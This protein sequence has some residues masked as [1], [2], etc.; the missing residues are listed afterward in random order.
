VT[1]NA[2]G[3]LFRSPEGRVLLLRR[4]DTGGWAYPG[5]HIEAGETPAE[6]AVREAME[7]V[8]YK[9]KHAGV[10]HTKRVRNGVNFTT[11]LYDCEEEFVPKLNHEHTDYMWIAPNLAIQKSMLPEKSAKKDDTRADAAWEEGKHPRGPDGKFAPIGS[12]GANP[13][14]VTGW[15]SISG[16]QGY[17]TGG[18]F[19]SPDG[20]QHYVKFPSE[21]A[22]KTEV[23]SG[24]ILKQIGVNTVNPVFQYTNNE[25][26]VSSE[27]DPNL[28]QLKLSDLT[29]PQ[30]L[31][32]EQRVQLAEMYAAAVLTNNWDAIGGEGGMPINVMM[33]EGTKDLTQL[34]L[35]GSFDFK[36]VGSAKPF[37][38]DPTDTLENMLNPAFSSGKV[39][40]KLFDKY[41]GIYQAA[42]KALEKIDMEQAKWAFKQ[43]GLPNAKGLFETF[44]ARKAA[45]EKAFKDKVA[46]AGGSVS[47]NLPA[48]EP[49]KEEP[50]E[51]VEDPLSAPLSE[52]FKSASK[53][54]ASM[55]MTGFK[56][57]EKGT[58]EYVAKQAE[59]AGLKAKMTS[60]A[61]KGYFEAKAAA[62]KAKKA[63]KAAAAKPAPAPAAPA[64]PVNLFK[65]A[66]NY[67]K[68]KDTFNKA[69]NELMAAEVGFM[70]GKDPEQY[71]E[72]LSKFEAE[73]PKFKQAASEAEQAVKSHFAGQGETMPAA[74]KEKYAELHDYIA[75]A[76]KFLSTK[77]LLQ[78]TIEDYGKK[79]NMGQKALQNHIAAK[80]AFQ[81]AK[82]AYESGP[83][84]PGTSAQQSTPGT[85]TPAASPYKDM[86]LENPTK[87]KKAFGNVS[88]KG[89]ARNESLALHKALGSA[90]G[91][92]MLHGPEA[93]AL[94]SYKGTG[95]KG[96]NAQ[97]RA[98]KGLS[99]AN[100]VKAAALDTATLSGTIP[101]N[102]VFYRG[103]KSWQEAGFNM[104][105]EHAVKTGAA[106]HDNGY[107]SISSSKQFARNWAGGG[108]DAILFE[109]K[110]TKESPGCHVGLAQGHEDTHEREVVLPRGRN[111]W[112]LTGYRT[113]TINGA[114]IHV[115]T[116][117]TM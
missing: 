45:M 62:T 68:S 111:L 95:Y 110:F 33:S 17:T 96:V 43:S 44:A 57:I 98:G 54:Y 29:D 56:G 73:L 80:Q 4:S 22:A 104:H 1:I 85:P 106:Y 67:D 10:F 91:Q 7:E 88:I 27:L 28:K 58:P 74:S 84:A 78:K 13:E 109:C 79:S 12:S 90:M 55:L 113:E 114:D 40:G 82:S 38:A 39:F 61:P 5:G 50:G 77:K 86:G 6:A 3:I 97:L 64:E 65:A 102:T 15:K 76:E 72:I 53:A 87:V 52:D 47:L 105:P 60:L 115:V 63:A 8:G 36:G 75:T 37:N 103:V 70:H 49:L 11:Y 71:K 31:T 59:L 35:G 18:V 2:S 117:E 112:K 94:A 16:A 21:K 89:M 51:A 46:L 69:V 25:P 92:K 48:M 9:V 42:L 30:A 26:S 83:K 93:I 100:A 20:T 107:V 41:P 14:H 108:S 19:Q 34:D 66:E 101:A 116:M 99:M 23:L 24:E 32:P 81:N